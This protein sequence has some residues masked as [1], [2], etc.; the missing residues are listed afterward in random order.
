MKN[1]LIYKLNIEDI[2]NVALQEIGRELTSGEIKSIESKISEN[3][4]WYDVIADAIND[5]IK[6][7]DS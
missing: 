5:N 1:E 6:T 2:Q 4:K 3:I 7:G